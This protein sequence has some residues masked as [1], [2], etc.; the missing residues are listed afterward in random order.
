[1]TDNLPSGT[2]FDS[3]N[4]S[5]GT[6][7]ESSGT[8]TC[9]LGTMTSGASATVLV[10]VIRQ[11]TGSITNQA[12]ISSDTADPDW[13]NNI[14][15]EATTVNPAAD[16]ALTKTGEPDPVLVGQQLTYTLEVVNTGPQD[17]D[18]V[19]LTDSLPSGVTFNSATPSQGTCSQASGTVSCSIG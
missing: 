4:P 10:K 7:Q 11:A 2:T 16:L 14:A 5:Q 17:A 13:T 15:L 6:C 8:V 18:N 9:A 3:A 12:N 1:V 19:S